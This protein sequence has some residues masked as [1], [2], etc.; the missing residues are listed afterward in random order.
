VTL[1]PTGPQVTWSG[2]SAFS[3]T[4]GQSSVIA[5]L[6]V[7]IYGISPI[8]YVLITGYTGPADPI[9][10]LP[11]SV[12]FV[13]NLGG[14][15]T[16]IPFSV[17]GFGSGRLELNLSTYSWPFK[18]GILDAGGTIQVTTYGDTFNFGRSVWAETSA[19]VALT[20]SL[21]NPN[22]QV[23]VD[24]AG[25]PP[26]FGG[27]GSNIW[28]SGEIDTSIFSTTSSGVIAND[29]TTLWAMGVLVNNWFGGTVTTQVNPP[30][31]VWEN[32]PVN[33]WIS[34]IEA[35]NMRVNPGSVFTGYNI[36][37]GVQISVGFWT[38]PAIVPPALV[39]D[40]TFSITNADLGGLPAGPGNPLGNLNAA[41]VFHHLTRG[42]VGGSHSRSVI[43]GA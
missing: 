14:P 31:P 16:P 35:N 5:T 13:S 27:F 41:L 39:P 10:G 4:A 1:P 15:A 43:I 6:P 30:V 22:A 25:F 42:M 12:N 20:I 8:L 36:Q 40:T 9:T 38:R 17:S 3:N 2:G 29:P 37:D 32:A 19:A 18:T 26:G 28:Y 7:G 21:V 33:T 34:V 11:W 24:D 23:W